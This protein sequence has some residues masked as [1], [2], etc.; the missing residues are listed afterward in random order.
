MSKIYY[1]EK[2]YLL[3]LS[4]I[5]H[6][7]V[8]VP[9]RTGVGSRAIF[10]AKLIWHEGQFPFFTH[11][12]IYQRPAF[13]EMWFM[14]RGKTQTKE[15]E[16]KGVKFW[17]GNT[18]REFLD[19]RGL[20][21]LPEGDMGVAY[22]FQWRRSGGL[23]SRDGQHHFTKGTD[24]LASLIWGLKNDKYGRRH[25]ISLWNP[26]QLEDMALT[27]CWWASQ[28]VVLPKGDGRDY[29][30]L[31]LINR[32]LDAPFGCVYAVQ[33]YRMLQLALCRM[34]GFELGTLSCDLSQVHIYHDQLAWVDEINRRPF[35]ENHSN[36]IKLNPKVKLENIH[37]LLQLEFTDWDIQYNDVNKTP[38]ET[39]K[40]KMAV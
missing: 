31:K 35:K 26:G 30:H 24:Q 20:A 14:L 34:F 4:E 39:Q 21:D 23:R 40:P 28:F 15:L 33:Q 16:D 32:S 2:G 38:F 25:L 10:D 29:L 8:D 36:T 18:S 5:Y 7:G 11:R 9:D 1:G 3:M 13:E 22:G 19:K 6:H 27:P 17:V 12:P 37:D